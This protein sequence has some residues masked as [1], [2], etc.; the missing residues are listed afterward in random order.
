MQIFFIDESGTIPPAD[1]VENA[2]IFALGGIIIP[3]DLWHEIDKELARLK[4][5]YRIIGEIKWRFFAP[6]RP[7]SK[8]TPLSHL[9]A[10][11]K[12]NLRTAIYSIIGNYSNLKY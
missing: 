8:T 1:K 11:E 10:F 2:P 3:E 7:E 6:S 9:S 12:E 4:K 5:Q